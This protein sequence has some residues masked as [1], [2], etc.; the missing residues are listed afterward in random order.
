MSE[1]RIVLKKNH[2]QKQNCQ[3]DKQ[4]NCCIKQFAGSI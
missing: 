1:S 2:K 4:K 3:Y